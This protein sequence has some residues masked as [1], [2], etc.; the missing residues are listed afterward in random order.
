MAGVRENLRAAAVDP[1]ITYT[2]VLG[3]FNF[4]E[5][6]DTSQKIISFYT[7]DE[8]AEG[9]PNWVF[10]EQLDFGRVSEQ[11]PKA[12]DRVVPGLRL[13]ALV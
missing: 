12:G 10:E 9:G 5:N 1:S 4:D 3:D 13:S 2:T 7:F 8:N 11:R 6:G